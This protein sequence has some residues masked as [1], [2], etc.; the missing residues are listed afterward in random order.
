VSG[1]GNAH[2]LAA[3]ADWHAETPRKWMHQAEV[4]DG[5]AAG[6]LPDTTRELWELCRKTKKLEQ[7]KY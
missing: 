4:D 6:V 5:E 1:T 3:V 7:T 2:D